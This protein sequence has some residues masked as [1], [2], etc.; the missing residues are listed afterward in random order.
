MD[1]CGGVRLEERLGG[2]STE[3][4]PSYVEGF[5]SPSLTPLPGPL[6]LVLYKGGL[7][8]QVYPST[9]FIPPAH[10]CLRHRCRQAVLVHPA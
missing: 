7:G 8:R 2:P 1:I 3:F 9:E 4:I 6:A 10:L 5:G